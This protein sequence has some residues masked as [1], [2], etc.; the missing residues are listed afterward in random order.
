MKESYLLSGKKA[1]LRLLSC[2]EAASVRG[3]EKGGTAGREPGKVV[4]NSQSIGKVC[5]PSSV[6]ESSLEK[7][8]LTELG[9]GLEDRRWGRVGGL[10]REQVR[11]SL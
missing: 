3:D 10:A 6:A 11:V 4:K 5:S 7:W 1:C 9:V 8:A 2:R